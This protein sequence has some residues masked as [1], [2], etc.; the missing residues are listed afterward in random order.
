[1]SKARAKGPRWRCLDMLAWSVLLTSIIVYLPRVGQTYLG[2]ISLLYMAPLTVAVV[3]AWCFGHPPE[4]VDG[5]QVWRLRAAWLTLGATAP[6][7]SWWQRCPEVLY[8]AIGMLVSLA[9]LAWALLESVAL[10]ACVAKRR[11]LSV[12]VQDT[13]IGRVALVYLLLIPIT[14]VGVTFVLAL[15]TGVASVPSDWLRFWR[16]IPPWG[17][18]LLTYCPLVASLNFSRLLF[19][20]SGCCAY[21]PTATDGELPGD[22]QDD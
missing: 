14:A 5:W 6:F 19:R 18:M 13:L 8:L 2:D 21:A 4:L 3:A 10:V 20:A 16:L 9:V 17:R 22:V 1:M 7:V 12:I 15:F 11:N